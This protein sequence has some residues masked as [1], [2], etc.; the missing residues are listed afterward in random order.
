MA[1]VQ[2]YGNTFSN[3]FYQIRKC[4]EVNFMVDDSAKWVSWRNVIFAEESVAPSIV[5]D[6]YRFVVSVGKK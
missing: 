2:P 3:A 4:L 6:V 1:S 5:L